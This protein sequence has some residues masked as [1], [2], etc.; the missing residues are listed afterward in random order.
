[1]LPTFAQIDTTAA[2][3]ALSDGNSAIGTIGGAILVLAA[4]VAVYA[5]VKRAV[6]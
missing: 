4:L 3:T 5:W 1:M 2:T 6:R